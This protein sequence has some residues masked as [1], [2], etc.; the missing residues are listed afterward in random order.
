M[1]PAVL[2]EW[3]TAYGLTD[4]TEDEM[5]LIYGA[6]EEFLYVKKADPEVAGINAHK[7][8]E[9]AEKLG[10]NG[11]YLP[12]NAKDCEGYAVCSFGCPS[13]A[14]QSTNVSY[15]PEAIKRGAE[16]YAD[17][18]VERILTENGRAVGVEGR[19]INHETGETGPKIR[20]DAKVVVLSCGTIGTPLLLM[21]NRL[22]N[23]S[24][25]VGKNYRLHPATQVI[26][27]FDERIDPYKGISQSAW[28]HDFIGEGISLE[29]SV[30]PPDM[31]AA[32]VPQ[33]SSRH[34]ESMLLYPHAGLFAAMLRDNSSGRIMTHSK[35]GFSILY[36]INRDDVRRMKLG[37]ILVSE[38]AFAAGAKKVYTLIRGHTELRGLKD[39]NRLKG[40]KVSARHFL[41]MSGWH[42]LGACRMGGDPAWS[43]VKQTGE[44]WDVENLYVSDASTFP[45]ALGVNPQL[46]IMA[47]SVRCAG[48]IDDR[49]EQMAHKSPMS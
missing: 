22:A 43:V 19:F 5:S 14:K 29:T 24:G 35:K 28:V 41:N 44:T 27:I 32:I 1:P 37:N 11:D 21:K 15:I 34:A 45:T 49:L 7:F 25:E 13:G 2:K 18:K 10:L 8:L 23:S 38:M 20:V 33:V 30:L 48:F 31:L 40:D 16:L 17:C 3:R 39:L 26:P 9:G 6:I 36:Q 47:L 4:M 42:P 46:T 12:R